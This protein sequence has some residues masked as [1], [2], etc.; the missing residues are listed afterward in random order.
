MEQGTVW[1]KERYFGL[2]QSVFVLEALKT[3]VHNHNYSD[4]S[5]AFFSLTK[6]GS[7]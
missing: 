4:Y 5:E 1:L 2:P 6:V 3:F 7:R